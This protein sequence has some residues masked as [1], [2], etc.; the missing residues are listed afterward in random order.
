MSHNIY[1]SINLNGNDIV[2]VK[3]IQ[4]T[5]D[6]SS[7]NSLVKK[8]QAETIA[9]T[10]V[11][12]GIVAA[13]ASASSDTSYS[14][15]FTQAA[16]DAKQPN[17][18]VDSQYFTLTNN[19]LGFKDL[20]IV[21][22]YKSITHTTL[23]EFIAASTFN[24][25]GT[26]TVSGE[27]LDKMSLIFLQGATNPAEKAFVYMGTNHG[28]AA[29]FVSF[30]VDYN[31]GTIRSFFAATGVGLTYT[32]GTGGYS[33]SFGT[34]AHD[35]GAQTVP[36]DSN[37]FT[38]VTGSTVLAI[39][40]ALEVLISDVD[41][42]ATGGQAT[43]NTR[44]D[45]LTGVTGNNMLTF[46]GGLL[47]ANKNIKQLLQELE[48]L[49]TSAIADRA[50]IRSEFAAADSNLNTLITTETTNRNTAVSHEASTRAS[51]DSALDV[52]IGAN[53]TAIT[54]ET[55]R[56]TLAESGITARLDIIEGVGDGS[57]AKAQAD[58]EAYTETREAA[59]MVHVNQNAT[60]ISKL[61]NGNIELIGTVDSHGVF[62]SSETD[63][64][65][66]SSFVSMHFSTGEIVVIAE[67]VTLFSQSFKTNDKLMAKTSMSAGTATFDKF[68]WTKADDSDITKANVGSSTVSLISDQ[69]AVTPDSIGRTQLD[70]VIEA[71][72]DDKVSLTSDSQTITGKALK[73][74]QTDTELGA[75]YGLYLKKTQAGTDPLTGTCRGL[76]VENDVYSSG[77]GS[78]LA[79]NYAHNSITTHYKGTCN[80]LSMVISGTY[81]EANAPAGT[82]ITAIGSY[83][84]STDQQLG[85]N[86][87]LFAAAE[88]GA[89][90]NVSILG[91]ASTNG[92]GADRGVVG[93]VTS[94]TLANY[95]ATRTA[96][97][98]PYN[99][100][101][102]AA[103]AKYAPAGSKALYAYGDCVLEGGKV[104]VP[105]ATTDTCAVNLSD[106]KGKQKIFNLDTTD[107]VSKTFSAGL[108]L[109]K[110][111]YQVI[112]AG[113]AVNAAVS[114]DFTN[115]E[116]TVTCS[117][118]NLTGVKLIVI[119]LYVDVTTV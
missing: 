115:D 27:I 81:S 59:V 60:D 112:H 36:V 62:T 32:V 11:Q 82:S 72:I 85:V 113:S 99:D 48:I 109:D 39:L 56:A 45:N 51:A 89:V 12:A 8:S 17:L 98:F 86:V 104:T 71:D 93:S 13:A 25:D 38:T 118:G 111:M 16:L 101:A 35:L 33:L 66:G 74:E 1:Q 24:G 64:R 77:S 14:S 20:G 10:A 84:V 58:A 70:S 105:S 37:E 61:S 116:I 41:A 42:A 31:E 88:N 53:T 76:L 69:L 2:Q 68:V 97:P 29:D 5:Q 75:S 117:G 110:C 63:S 43:V 65:N 54:T 108:D 26:L 103:D 21:K 79:P 49:H 57:V 94:Q 95:Q 22:P 6:G 30:S 78:A 91:Y 55:N 114:F 87:G 40:K 107:A 50:A 44:M 34:S 52:K 106:I 92:L 18:S 96:D 102:I 83:A 19:T 4:T 7:E 15:L 28:S 119:E 73:I 9:A 100:I 47:S 80:D 90:S 67:P 3:D 46:S 23:A